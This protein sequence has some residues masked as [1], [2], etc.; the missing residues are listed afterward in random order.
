V[1]PVFSNDRPLSGSAELATELR[2]RAWHV[3]QPTFFRHL[4]PVVLFGEMCTQWRS[5]FGALG[6]CSMIALPWRCWGVAG[7]GGGGFLNFWG[8]SRRGML[9][10]LACL[11]IC[12]RGV[13]LFWN[14]FASSWFVV[15]SLA[16]T[17]VVP[18]RAHRKSLLLLDC[19]VVCCG[20]KMMKGQLWHPFQKQQGE[21]CC[22]TSC[23]HFALL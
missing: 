8:E 4:P 18:F 22:P 6:K 7:E 21:P 1:C 12:E 23:T 5:L 10:F 2:L 9:G 13:P 17:F 16:W 15:S 20:T 3:E 19:A 14:Q 11:V